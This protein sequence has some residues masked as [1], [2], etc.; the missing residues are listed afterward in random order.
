MNKTQR[1]KMTPRRIKREY[2]H[3]CVIGQF[4][5][6]KQT[7][8]LVFNNLFNALIWVFVALLFTNKIF[9]TSFSFASWLSFLLAFRW[10]FTSLDRFGDL[11][12]GYNLMECYPVSF[13]T[14]IAMR[15]YSKWIQI[16]EWAFFVLGILVCIWTGAPIF[17]A[18][19]ISLSIVL[20]S[21]I[22]EEIV[23]FLSYRAINTVRFYI[24]LLAI[25]AILLWG[26]FTKFKQLTLPV[27]W[28]LPFTTLLT[29]ASVF[30]LIA[31]KGKKNKTDGYKSKRVLRCDRTLSKRKRPMGTLGI[32]L[33]REFVCLFRHKIDTLI[34]AAVFVFLFVLMSAKGEMFVVM[35]PA[36]FAMDFA[37]NYSCNIFGVEGQAVELL[38]LSPV[39]RKKV[40][41]AKSLLTLV[42][43]SLGIII[44]TGVVFIANKADHIYQMIQML[45]IG[46]FT[47]ALLMAT[48]LYASIKYYYPEDRKNPYKIKKMLF[49]VAVYAV[50]AVLVAVFYF[51]NITAVGWIILAALAMLIATFAT[52]LEP[53]FFAEMLQNK[54]QEIL[55]LTQML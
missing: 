3:F 5:R 24:T 11:G 21:E 20:L 29:V 27:E 16:S 48:S 52:I 26:S 6:D 54:E 42:V 32:L 36:F 13:K 46:F 38:I 50:E 7:A 23:C 47:L 45:S 9:E 41:K 17:M 30:V 28:V 31:C 44:F 51:M 33:Q 35:L 49:V 22:S 12:L 40:L 10:V 4:V 1:N 37:S 14:V 25:V 15:L 19:A 8:V 39:D 34:S 2:V 18:V 53:A 55:R 43:S